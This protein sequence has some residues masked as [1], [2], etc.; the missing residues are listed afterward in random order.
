MQERTCQRC[1]A[2]FVP[3]RPNAKFCSGEC[4]V[5]TNRAETRVKREAA[6]K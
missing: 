6:K 3:T 1:N 5:A 2:P 4:Q